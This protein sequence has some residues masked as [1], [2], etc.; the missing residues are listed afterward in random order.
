MFSIDGSHTYFSQG[1][2]F[3]LIGQYSL[4]MPQKSF[5]V[6]A[7]A[8]YGD[9]YFRAALFEDRPFEEYKSFVLRVSGN[10]CVWTRMADGIQS[11]LVDKIA[12][13]TVVHQAWRP[14]IVYLNGQYWGHYNLRERVSR[15]FVAQHEGMTLEEADSITILEANSK[16]YYGSNAEYKGC[17]KKQENVAGYQ[18]GGYAISGRQYR[19]R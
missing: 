16:A 3:G 4:D 8:R 11:R 13:T 18:P 7:R 14:V 1:V 15:Y 17:W 6:T 9:K 12:D 2:T 19:Y 5:K 10:D